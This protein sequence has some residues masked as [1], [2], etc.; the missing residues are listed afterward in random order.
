MIKIRYLA[1]LLLISP[2][3]SSCGKISQIEVGEV[4]NFQIKGFEEN[5]LLVELTLPVTNPSRHKISVIGIDA[6]IYINQD[7]LGH[8]NSIDTIVIPRKSSGNYAVLLRVRMANPLGAALTVMNFRQGQKINL[9][10]EGDITTKASF[11]RKKLEIMEE[12]N[13]VL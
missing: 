11:I 13:V 10:I 5:A 6:K 9:K 4:N 7:Y 3:F 8:I 12:R 1:L 2:V